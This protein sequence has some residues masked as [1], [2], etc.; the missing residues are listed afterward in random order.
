[1]SKTICTILAAGAA[2]GGFS[3]SAAVFLP[4]NSSF[5]MDSPPFIRHIFST[6]VNAPPFY[7]TFYR[8]VKLSFK[9]GHSLWETVSS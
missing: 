9:S 3:L 1:M 5:A 7:G 2:L 8:F 6:F 4:V